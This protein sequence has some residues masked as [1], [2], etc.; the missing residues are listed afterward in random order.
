M[1][2]FME[3]T[4]ERE[5]SFDI[6][7]TLILGAYMREWQMPEYRVILKKPETGAYVEI[8]Y[9]PAVEGKRLRGLQQ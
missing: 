6:R 9:F 5:L 3:S 4:K 1:T 2:I 8:Y 7:R